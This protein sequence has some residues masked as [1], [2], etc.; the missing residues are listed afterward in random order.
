MSAL[1]K[2]LHLRSLATDKNDFLYLHVWGSLLPHYTPSQCNCAEFW[3]KWMRDN[4]QEYGQ[5]N[6]YFAW[7]VKLHNAVNIKLKRDAWSFEDALS[8]WTDISN[9]ESDQ[10]KIV[11]SCDEFLIF[12]SMFGKGNV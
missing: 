12:E 1:W 9:T 6:I 8:Y 11:D 4:P 3:K 5:P 10:P 2:E 7:T